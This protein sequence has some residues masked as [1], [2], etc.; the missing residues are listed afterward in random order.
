MKPLL[1][2]AT[3]LALPRAAF[4]W[5]AGLLAVVACAMAL[6]A[7]PALAGMTMAPLDPDTQV[8][9]A[10]EPIQACCVATDTD[11]DS[12]DR[13]WALLPLPAAV[14]AQAAPAPAER[15]QPWP[16]LN[17]PPP[18]RPPRARA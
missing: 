17:L 14:V 6:L 18:Q 7:S 8:V 16:G 15:V 3:C 13:D 1:P 9:M 10:D 11:E 12:L 4:A 2:T 5:V